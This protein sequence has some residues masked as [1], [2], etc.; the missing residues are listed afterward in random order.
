MTRASTQQAGFT[1]I[2]ALVA[3][4]IV[5]FSL[6]AISGMQLSLSRNADVAKQRTEASR[7]AEEKIEEFRSFSGITSGGVN[8]NGLA[9]GS[10]SISGYT[11]NATTVIP[12]NTTF[13]RTW[14]V[15]GVVGD[16]MRSMGVTVSWQDRVG[17]TQNIFLTTSISKTDPSDSGFLNFPLEQNT[18]IKRP[19]NRSL[20]IPITAID[21]GG[22]KSSY[23]FASNYAVIFSD[24]TG[25][26]V[27]KCNNT[28]NSTTYN[29]N[30][31]GCTPFNGYLLAGYVSGAL[32]P[33]SGIP[34]APS[35]VNTAGLTGWD[36]SNG[37][38][39]SCFYGQA[40]NQSTNV[41]LTGF[42]YYSCVIPVVANGTYA[43]TL[44]LGGVS[45]IGNYKV[46]RFQYPTANN[47]SANS[48]NVQP[49]VGVD[50]SLD[51]QN[52]YIENSIN[53]TCPAVGGLALVLHQDCRTSL[54]P[55]TNILGTCPLT[56]HNTY[57]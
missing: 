38:S 44:K 30:S 14:T 12:T 39:I 11:V 42:Y 21:V 40:R 27:E 47:T 32:I 53:A 7:L 5:S 22:G 9:S 19:K 50:E 8:W 55:S 15:G 2:E 4:M 26:V 54:S 43:G 36:S 57:Q 24:A 3:L 52:F 49:Y 16:T 51:N 56:T 37:K 33:T 10:D 1:F 46:C 18:T 17:E 20:N 13:T 48:R 29:N 34:V 28:V 23:Q 35:G 31:A 6:L 45:I 25:A 41:P